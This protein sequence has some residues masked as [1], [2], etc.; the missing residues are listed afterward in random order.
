MLKREKRRR[1]E[2]V[3]GMIGEVLS[4]LGLTE[5]LTEYQAVS[6]W[7]E[8]VGEQVARHTQ[9]EWIENSE[10]TVR[11]DSHTWIQ[12]LTFLKPEIIGKLN[13]RLGKPVVKEI[14]FLISRKRAT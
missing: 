14:R 5:Q 11:V 12:E 10:L 7:P 8:V 6:V 4:K 13:T 1:P 9:A 2:L 3:S